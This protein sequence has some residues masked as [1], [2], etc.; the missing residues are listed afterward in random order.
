MWSAFED[1]NPVLDN[2]ERLDDGDRQHWS[3]CERNPKVVGWRITKT[4]QQSNAC[5]SDLEK[6]DRLTTD[7][8]KSH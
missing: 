5:C 7:K 2:P 6:K 4:M 1:S 8:N 3:T